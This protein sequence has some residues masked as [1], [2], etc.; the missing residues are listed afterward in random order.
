VKEDGLAG[1]TSNPSIFE[2]A[3]GEGDEYKPALRKLLESKPD[4]S[5]MELYEALAIRDIQDACAVLRPC[6]TERR[7][8]T[9]TSA[10]R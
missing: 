6:S 4:A 9:G 10:S 1:V 8:A 2:K 3:I 7:A 5:A